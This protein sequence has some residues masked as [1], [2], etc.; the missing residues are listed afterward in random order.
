MIVVDTN[1]V[2]YYFIEGDKTAMARE[3]MRADPD[4]R[5]PALWRHEYLNVLATYARQGGAT[6]AESREL[7]RL[8]GNLL[9][10]REQQVEPEAALALAVDHKLSAYD[11]QYI[12]LA[13]GLH[14]VLVTEDRRLVKAFPSITRTM[15]GFVA[16]GSATR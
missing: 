10:S 14:T 7:W 3:L 4:W 1:V 9:S 2:A 6:V 16:S 11:A 12:V 13:Q 8:A 5:L 15:Q